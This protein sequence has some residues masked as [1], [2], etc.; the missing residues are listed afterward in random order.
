MSYINQVSLLSNSAA[1]PVNSSLP[2]I[3]SAPTSNALTALNSTVI[4]QVEGGG[5]YYLTLTNPSNATSAW[6]GTVT[7]QYSTDGITYNSLTVFPVTPVTA[8]TSTATANGLFQINIPSG[9]T[10][11]VYVQAIMSAYTSGTVYFYL[12]PQTPNTKVLLPWTY[13]IT[14]GN[15][16][17][18]PIDTSGFSEVDIQI[19]A[20]TGVSL[21]AQGT[22]D[23]SFT[24]WGAIGSQA[25]SSTT[26]LATASSYLT[27]TTT[28]TFRM[29]T[30]GYKWFR[31]Q[32]TVTGTVLTIQGVS[33]V[34]G[35][36]QL[37]SALGN[38]IA[39]TGGNIT[40]VTS[41]T[42]F[43]GKTI[44][45][46]QANGATNYANNVNLAT[47]T[48]NADYSAQ[49]WAATSGVGATIADAAGDGQSVSFA[50]NVTA[51]TAGSSTGLYVYLQE[52]PD[53]GTTW[54]DIWG[55][56]PFTSVGF[57]RI[58]AI[59]IGGRRRMRWVNRAGAATTATV[60]VTA[61]K[62]FHFPIQR[63]F[64]DWGTTGTAANSNLITGAAATT[65]TST[66]TSGL[67]TITQTTAAYPIDGCKLI[68]MKGLVTGGT[69]T[70][71]PVLTLQVSDDFTNWVS[72][73]TTLTLPLTAGM[74]MVTLNGVAAKYVR[75][76]LTTAQSGGTA[77]ALSYISF[78]GLN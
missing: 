52:S 70:T 1:V 75:A 39:V 15:I 40:A 32:C 35:Q 19:S 49:A 7:F 6:V 64:F 4:Y 18:G 44:N 43:N 67:A 13:G 11:V 47:A 23:P 45:S 53:N 30:L 50:V 3:L 62:S 16:L 29:Q 78:L 27:I 58:P 24:T 76:N 14:S 65:S 21:Q 59:P 20:N 34:I 60:T 66:L 2:I 61:M 63:Q 37:L 41:L 5:V 68:T 25:S 17:V 9:I 69:A 71:A 38:S 46:I 28:D 33:A 10:S 57:A 42:G 48:S 22:N 55:C 72:T 36:P 26:G 77:I 12:A 54:T 56:E 51:W 8:N 74:A 73:G 31:I